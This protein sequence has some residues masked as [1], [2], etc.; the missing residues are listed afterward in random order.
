MSKFFRS[1]LSVLLVVFLAMAMVTPC[2]AVGNAS[3]SGWKSVSFTKTDDSSV[4][5]PRRGSAGLED[6]DEIYSADETVRVSI[7][8]DDAATITKFPTEGI[9]ANA[10]A[11]SYRASLRTKQD[12]LAQ[13]ISALALDGEELD[14]VWHL[15]LAAN[16]I[17]ANVKYGRIGAIANVPG[18]RKVLVENRYEPQ[19]AEESDKPANIGAT[20][21]TGATFVWGDY[22]GA[23]QIVAI[24]DT[25]LDTDHRSFDPGAFEYAISTL[26]GEFDLLTKD[27]IAAVLKSLNVYDRN[28]S[29]TARKLYINSKAPFGYNYCDDNYDVTHDND[30]QGEHGSHVAGIAAANRFVKKDGEYVDALAEVLT[31]GEAPDAQILAMKV[32]GNNGGAYDSDYFAAVEDAIVLGASAA[33]LSLGSGSA[34]DSFDEYYQ[35]VM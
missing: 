9:A 18:V 14:V 32:F 22:T 7:V 16:V 12:S 17:S 21:M 8:L 28:N 2:F 34:G 10:N 4:S 15:T 27:D 26:Q 19:K 30:D 29:V 6:L 1:S 11:M 31:Q 20:E 13:R 33:N 5:A 3:Q 24:I 23:G 25:G 35:D